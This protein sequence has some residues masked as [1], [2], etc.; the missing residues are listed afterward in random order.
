MNRLDWFSVFKYLVYA[1][2]IANAALFFKDDWEA[3]AHVFQDG[4]P[5]VRIIEGFAPSI[6]TAAW[7]ILLLLFELETC[8]LTDEVLK[9]PIGLIIRGLRALCY[10]VI[11]YAFTGY[12]GKAL[13]FGLYVPADIPNACALVMQPFSL[14][15][16]LDEYRALTAM[17]CAGIAGDL[18]VNEQARTLAEAGALTQATRLA[19]VDVVNSGTWLLIL[20]LLELDVRPR[21]KEL[22]PGWVATANRLAKYLLYTI[23]LGAAVYWGLFGTFLDFWDAF[24]W[25][26]AFI[27]IERNVFAWEREPVASRADERGFTDEG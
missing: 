27:F 2:L 5:F 4:L 7:V 12:L 26:A 16:G 6:D 21:V 10:V 18:F 25:I 22:F 23:I 15:V 3:A 11:V 20:A 9:R 13:G 24:L 14:L 17:N 8:Q 1:A 19:W